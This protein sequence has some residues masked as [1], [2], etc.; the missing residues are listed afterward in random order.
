MP[1]PES[2]DER[3]LT[4]AGL[5]HD[6]RNV[7]ETLTEAAELLR[8]D[9]NWAQLAGA[10]RRAA[11]RGERIAHSLHGSA[12]ANVRAAKIVERATEAVLDLHDQVEFHRD[13]DN[14]LILPGN[15][16]EWERVLLNLLLNAARAMPHGG[17]IHVHASEASGQISIRVRDHGP[18]IAPEILPRIFEPRFSTDDAHEG[19]GLHIVKTIVEK[20]GGTVTARNHGAQ[21]S[22]QGAEFAICLCR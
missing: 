17:P 12:P 11:R 1:G 10:I 5:V 7:F 22:H 8:E 2:H 19:L 20:H 9:E 21:G 4:L 3:D 18:G 16:F 14:E 15:P 13:V 6:L